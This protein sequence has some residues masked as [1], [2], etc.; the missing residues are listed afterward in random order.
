ME[1]KVKDLRQQLL[2]FK[3]SKSFNQNDF[4]VSE[5]NIIIDIENGIW[6]VK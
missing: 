1:N 6:K 5:S 3:F 2:N 4:F